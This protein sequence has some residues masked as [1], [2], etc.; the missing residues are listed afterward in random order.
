MIAR[1]KWP[2]CHGALKLD[3]CTWFTTLFFLTSLQF[4]LN[5]NITS[6]MMYR[7]LCGYTR[8][9]LRT[10]CARGNYHIWF[11]MHISGHLTAHWHI[12]W[13]LLKHFGM[14]F[15]VTGALR[16]HWKWKVYRCIKNN[17]MKDNTEQYI[18]SARYYTR[19]FTWLHCFCPS[20]YALLLVSNCLST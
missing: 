2:Y 1:T 14:P 7:P 9:A 16:K 5:I 10:L 17:Y 11:F 15:G 12:F 3:M 8:D 20:I 13:T 19:I 6:Y 4:I 18:C